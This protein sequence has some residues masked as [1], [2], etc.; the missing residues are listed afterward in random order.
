[1]KLSIGTVISRAFSLYFKLF[2]T[3]FVGAFAVFFVV[4]VGLD[5]LAERSV[6]FLLIWQFALSLLGGALVQGLAVTAVGD[7]EDEKQDLGMLDLFRLAAPV[8]GL[9]ALVSLLQTLAVVVGFVLLIIPG[10]LVLTWWAVAIPAVVVDRPGVIGAF[11]RSVDLVRGNAWRVFW[12]GF[13][14][15]LIVIVAAIVVG[16]AFGLVDVGRVGDVIPSAVT[17]P[18]SAVGYAVLYFELRRMKADASDQVSGEG[19]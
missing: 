15:L 2:G 7:L 16:L 10:L 18:F 8:M 17:A 4:E 14:M 3:L 5:V 6:R 19:V 1:M 9:V 13:L 12:L 11:G